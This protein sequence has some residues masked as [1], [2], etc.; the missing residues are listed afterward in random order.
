MKSFT[1][2]LVLSLY[3]FATLNIQ[4]NAFEKKNGV[5]TIN[6]QND[7]NN[8]VGSDI[9][10]SVSLRSKVDMILTRQRNL[11][12]KIDD[13]EP[14]VTDSLCPEECKKNKYKCKT[15]GTALALS[16]T[17]GIYGCDRFYLG[18]VYLG[19]L[20]IVTGILGCCLPLCHFYI[21]GFDA[22]NNQD[23]AKKR[24]KI[25]PTQ[26]FCRCLNKRS[27]IPCFKIGNPFYCLT[28]TWFLTWYIYDIYY[29]YNEGLVD[30]FNSN[31][32]CYIKQ[33]FIEK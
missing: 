14:K 11:L 33:L 17:L 12:S 10:S 22:P 23:K 27:K 15:K 19:A 6:K 29:I 20:K 30:Q 4:A 28:F 25:R 2:S 5:E 31:P 21:F 32:K 9:T 3:I 13:A 18:Y 7:M 8:N 1:Y 26:R 16:I 24:K